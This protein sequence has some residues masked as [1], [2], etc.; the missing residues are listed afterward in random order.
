MPS[1]AIAS[2]H[3]AETDG[4]ASAAHPVQAPVRAWAPHSGQGLRHFTPNGRCSLYFSY[5]CSPSETQNTCEVRGRKIALKQ[6]TGGF[7]LPW[8]VSF[9]G[10]LPVC[11]PQH[12]QAARSRWLARR[13]IVFVPRGRS[14]AP[15]LVRRSMLGDDDAQSVCARALS[16]H[17]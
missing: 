3:C 8:L 11:G 6:K 1:Y 2:A 10:V 4:K 5:Q 13:F 14:P 12:T 7:L 9:S 17:D 16:G 15:A